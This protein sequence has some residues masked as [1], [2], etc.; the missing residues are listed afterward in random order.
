[1]ITQAQDHDIPNAPENDSPQLPR[2]K[3]GLWG[4]ESNPSRQASIAAKASSPPQPQKSQSS[5]PSGILK[6]GSGASEHRTNSDVGCTVESRVE[7]RV[8][9]RV[10][11]HHMHKSPVRAPSRLRESST[12]EAE[13]C[14]A[15]SSRNAHQSSRDSSA[16]EEEEDHHQKPYKQEPRAEVTTD[17]EEQ[18]TL[19]HRHSP[20]AAHAPR[21]KPNGT[22]TQPH[23]HYH[24]AEEY[25]SRARVQEALSPRRQPSHNRQYPAKARILNL[26]DN[27]TLAD[28][29]EDDL[30][31]KVNASQRAR[32]SGQDRAQVCGLAGR[33]LYS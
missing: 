17:E 9:S 31:C 1:M 20:R 28:E 25:F 19:Q 3:S 5:Q 10:P 13:V 18:R 14:Y 8:V 22:T 33:G 16:E 23:Q 12:E 24:T 27:C 21:Q 7:P 15:P 11:E 2:Q 26:H 6:T 29:Q 32:D 30:Y 4:V